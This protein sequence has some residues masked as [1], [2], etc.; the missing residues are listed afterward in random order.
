MPFWFLEPQKPDL[1]I[2]RPAASHNLSQ[3]E[4]MSEGKANVVVL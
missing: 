1:D 4:F 3:K 2:L